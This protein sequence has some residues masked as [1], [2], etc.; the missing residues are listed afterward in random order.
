MKR[1]LLETMFF[2]FFAWNV[3]P[4]VGI[5]WGVILFVLVSP[6]LIPIKPSVASSARS[7]RQ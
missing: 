6:F 1:Y 5:F 3:L 2:C 7:D 4:V